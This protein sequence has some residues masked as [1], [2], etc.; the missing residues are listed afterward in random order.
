[1]RQLERLGI[2]VDTVENGVEALE[3][4]SHTSYDL[5]FMDCDMPHMDG[6][7]ATEEIRRLEGDTRH[8]LV[9]ALTASVTERDRRR[10][11][12][13]GMDDCVVK[14]VSEAE[15]KRVLNK[16]VLEDLGTIEASTVSILMQIGDSES[17]LLQEVIAIYIADAPMRINSMRHALATRNSELLWSAAHRLKSSSGN[18]GAT[19]VRDICDAIEKIGRSGKVQEAAQLIDDLD[20][21]YV[22]AERTLR[23]LKQE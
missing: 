14:P 20:A 19:R 22:H 4:M 8:T 12:A 9:I 11:L 23:S 15:L 7:Q 2:A 13:A 3:A 6:F 17:S 1:M 16:W 10:C 18:V 21:E 5:L